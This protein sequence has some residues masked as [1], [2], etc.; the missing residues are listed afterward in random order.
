MLL[1]YQLVI[2]A[3]ALASLT[4]TE[5]RLLLINYMYPNSNNY[6]QIELHCVYHDDNMTAAVGAGFQLNGTDIREVIDEVEVIS[7]NGLL[8][9]L[10]QEQEGFVTCSLNGSLSNNTLGFAGIAIGSAW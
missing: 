4:L 2:S 5:S 3:L 10:T 9:N 7:D 6:S 1:S 8:F